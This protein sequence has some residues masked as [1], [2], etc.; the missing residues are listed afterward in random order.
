[1]AIASKFLEDAFK[2]VLFDFRE[3]GLIF[4][5]EFKRVILSLKF[6]VAF[7]LILIPSIIFLNS[8][9]EDFEALILDLGIDDFLKFCTSG[10]IL[11]GQFLLQLIGLML[12]LDCFGKSTNDSMER[13]FALP[14]KKAN[15]YIAHMLTV[16][17]GTTITSI[18]SILTFDLIL[19]IWIGFSLTFLLMLKAFFMLMVGAILAISLTTLFVIIS[20]YFNFSSSIAIIPTLFLFY[21][22]PFLVNFI[23]IFVYG[24]PEAY[25]WTFMYQL[26][27]ATDYILQVSSGIS[28]DLPLIA[29]LTAWVAIAGI[30][31]LSQRIALIIFERIEK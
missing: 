11:I 20:N 5:Y 1:M 10:Y 29:N 7:S 30:S 13:Y 3:I 26:I 17:V 18:A 2:G 4:R 23:T 19:W 15:I 31:F 24:I 27:V 14:I 22:I 6:F 9:V 8:I 28:Q 25:E 16:I 12:T 21:I